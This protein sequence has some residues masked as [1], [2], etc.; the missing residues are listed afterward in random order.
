MHPLFEYL[1][2]LMAPNQRNSAQVD[3]EYLAQP[4]SL[5]FK[6]SEAIYTYKLQYSIEITPKLPKRI[7]DEIGDSVDHCGSFAG[8]L[9]Y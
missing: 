7:Q 5:K 4:N 1:S 3:L 2:D 8:A 9:P 6:S